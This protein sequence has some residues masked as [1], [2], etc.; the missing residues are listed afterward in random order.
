MLERILHFSIRNRWLVVLATVVVAA[1][2]AWSLK[3]LPIDAVPDIT[4]NQVQIN[5]MF[6]ALSPGEIETQVTFPIETSLAGIPGL[7][8]TRSLSR[9]GF[10]QVTAVFDDAVDIYFARQQVLERLGDAREKLPAGAEPR[11]GAIST[12]L[13]E[14]YMYTVEFEHPNGE[15]APLAADGKPGWQR[16]GTYL[17]PE[18]QVLVNDF[19]RA[20]YLR[21]VQDWIISPQLRG[22]KGVAAVDSIGGYVKQYHVQPDPMK[23]VSYG[24]TFADVIDA[25]EANNASTGAGYIEHK[26]ESYTVRATGRIA[27]IAQIAKIVVG[28]QGGTPIHMDDVASVGLGKELR[29]GTG[30]ENSGEVVVGTAMMLIGSNSRIVS[31][32]VDAKVTAINKNLPPDIRAKVVLNRTKLVDATIATVTKNL[33]EGAILVIVILFLLLGNIRAAI[34]CAL[35]IP[36]SMLMTATGMVQGKVTGNL[37]SLGAIDFGLIVDG[38]VIIVENCLRRLAEK[39]HHEGRLLTLQERLHEVMVAAKEMIQPSVYGQAII[40]IV[41]F[42]ILSLSGVEGKMFVPMATTVILALVAAFILSMTLVPALVAILIRGRVKEGDNFIIR[43]AKAVYAPALRW[44]VRWRWG[45]VGAAVL[46]FA[47]SLVMFTRLGQEFIPVLDERDIA[48]HALRIP[49]TGLTQ[50]MDIQ[51]EVERAVRSVPEV[52][53]VYSKTGTAEMASDPMPP[54]TSDTFIILKPKDQWPNPKVAKTDII[55]RIEA[56][57]EQVPGSRYEFLQP[58]QMRFN[59][60][61]AGVRSDVAVKVFGDDFEQMGATATEIAEAIEKIDGAEDVQVEVTEGLPVMTIDIDRDAIARY[62]ITVREV[63]D[64]V[65]AAIGGREAGQVFEGDRRFDLVVRL[66]DDIRRDINALGT[67]P[68]PLPPRKDAP[69]NAVT[70]TSFGPSENGHID[71]LSSTTDRPAYIPLAALAKIAVAEGPNQISR[72]NGKRR[73]VVQANVRGR[74][75]GSFVAEAQ[76]KVQ[77]VSL[78]PGGYLEWGGQFENLIAARARLTVVVPVCFLLIFLLLFS[79]FNSVKYA[80]LVFSGIPLGLTGGVV[81][82]WLRGMPFSI[83]AAVGF[84]ALSGVAVLNGLVMVS[85]INQLR[86]EGLS[87]GDAIFRGSLTRLRPV[88]MTALVASLGFVP[89]AIATGTGAEVQRPLA[90]VVIGGLISSTLLTLLVLPAL[91][92]IFTGSDKTPGPEQWEKPAPTDAEMVLTPAVEA[93]GGVSHVSNAAESAAKPSVPPSTS[94]KPQPPAKDA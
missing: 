76:Q 19:E 49:S 3:R 16:D 81:A 40:I 60:L 26:G 7:E 12:G 22:V 88:L 62:S 84:I 4:N 86:R 73:I 2:G 56:A 46:A 21:T 14:I 27:S 5:T 10:S 13:G 50:S 18:G 67:L 36:L 37:M 20:A 9:N 8:Y 24:F 29:S 47:G 68:I 52:A 92:R 74:D 78:P 65:S 70:L 42:P 82:L 83:S 6:P 32:A 30:S 80:L 35:A 33:A 55:A 45:V 61:I 15:Q 79:T 31:S 72:E 48:M 41:Y 58:I 1:V 23:L 66:P 51:F 87:V 75:L 39:Q 77:A 11:M 89:M 94:I 91:Y 28:E 17:T 38:A 57:V 53:F 59:E 90:T 54:S 25:L 43:G 93:P 63:Q 69:G 34:I 44:A 85:F 64:I 71:G